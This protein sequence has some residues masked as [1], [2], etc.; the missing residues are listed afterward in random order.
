MTTIKRPQAGACDCASVAASDGPYRATAQTYELRAGVVKALAHPVRLYIVDRLD[1]GEHCVCELVEL[2][3]LDQSTVSRHLAV[4]K[5]V[6]IVSDEK[7]GRQ[8]WYRL[9]TPC[10]TGFFGCIEETLRS[11]AAATTRA[12][13]NDRRQQ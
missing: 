11:T 1:G 3:G 13:G 12:L 8:T 9:R 4:L 2:I 7:R 6:G 5:A 10:I